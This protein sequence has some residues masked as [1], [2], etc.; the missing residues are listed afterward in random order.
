MPKLKQAA[1]AKTQFKAY[2]LERRHEKNKLATME[3]TAKTQPNNKPLQSRLKKV[4]NSNILYT[5]NRKSNGHSCKGLYKILGFVK[6]QLNSLMLKSK[7][8]IQWYA[9]TSLVCAEAPNHGQNMR[10]QLEALGFKWK[11]YGKRK[12]KKTAR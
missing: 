1:S 2:A 9:G 12:Y 11:G 5:R 8:G 6:N 10:T 4:L 7:L 3:R